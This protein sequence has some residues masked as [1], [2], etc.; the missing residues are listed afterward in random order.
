MK[1]LRLFFVTAA[2]LCFASFIASA[3]EIDRK[4]ACRADI[5][6]FCKDV[7]TGQGRLAQCVKQH[8][9]DLSLACREL[10]AEGKK[11]A[12]EFV[13]DCKPDAEKFCKG[14]EPGKGRVLKCLKAN[15]AKLSPV[16]KAHF[17]K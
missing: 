1:T 3:Q 7:K 11:K 16:C 6:K 14:V 15:E 9:G 17:K 10:I 2:I 5:E 4:G 8:E 12:G 13:N